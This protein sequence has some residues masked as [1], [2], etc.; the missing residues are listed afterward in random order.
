MASRDKQQLQQHATSSHPACNFGW[1][2][3]GTSSNRNHA[4][5]WRAVQ[6]LLNGTRVSTCSV[7]CCPSSGRVSAELLVYLIVVC[8]AAVQLLLTTSEASASVRRVVLRRAVLPE[9]R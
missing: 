3:G 2:C 6:R 9:G 1:K 8:L 7:S 4:I 5:K